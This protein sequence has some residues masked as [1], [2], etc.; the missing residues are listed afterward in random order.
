MKKLDV[1]LMTL[2]VAMLAVAM[3]VAPLPVFGGNLQDKD[4]LSFELEGF[5]VSRGGQFYDNWM[6]ATEADVPQ[7]THPAYPKEGRQEGAITWR[8]KECHGW[9]YK[10]RDGTYGKGEHLTGIKGIRNWVGKSPDKVMGIIRDATHRYGESMITVKAARKIA[11]FVTRGQL[12]MD[13]F[14]DPTT[15]MAHGDARRGAR[16]YQ[17]ICAFCHG[18]DGR[19]L[20]FGNGQVPE[21]I[22]TLAANNPW[23]FLHK[24]RNGEPG[25]PMVAMGT[26][27]I[28][29][30]VDILAY[31][32][33]LP[34][35]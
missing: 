15:G 3:L 8:C 29:E 11:L 5:V 21:F 27:S 7:T 6:A 10:G 20:N 9:D 23:E 2:A 16:V 17:A 14:I 34:E 4:I 24:V 12:E 26:L 1:R 13:G 35:K 32:Q 28:S 18:V 25:F 30:Q 33:T 31:S 19:A 22:G